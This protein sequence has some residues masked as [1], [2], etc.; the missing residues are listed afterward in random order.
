MAPAF[1]L[2]TADTPTTPVGMGSPRVGKPTAPAAPIR[3]PG[4]GG[5]TGGGTIRR[6]LPSGRT[7]QKGRR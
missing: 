6:P 3:L 5:A 1:K 2:P 4:G 7:M